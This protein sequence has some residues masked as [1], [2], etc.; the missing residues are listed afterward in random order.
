MQRELDAAK[1]RE[2]EVEQRLGVVHSQLEGQLLAKL[3]KEEEIRHVPFSS[4]GL[5]ADLKNTS[6]KA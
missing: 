5:G 3:E 1:V 2:M 4:A 6:P